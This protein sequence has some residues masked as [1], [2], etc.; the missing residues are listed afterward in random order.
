MIARN[1][2]PIS[3]NTDLMQNGSLSKLQLAKYQKKLK[4]AEQYQQ[5]GNIPKSLTL[6]DEIVS[7]NCSD[8]SIQIRIA[9]LL[10]MAGRG[11]AAI[12]Y[13][14][15]SEA[16]KQGNEDILMLL[17]SYYKALGMLT[18]AVTLYRQIITRNNINC[19]ALLEYATIHSI[20]GNHQHAIEYLERC[21]G[22]LD[23]EENNCKPD[24]S[25]YVDC[26]KALGLSYAST[27]EFDKGLVSYNKA[28][29]VKDDISIRT[30][31]ANLYEKSGDKDSA[32]E[33]LSGYSARQLTNVGSAL[34][35]SR[36]L[37]AHNNPG[38]CI[39]I[40][41]ATVKSTRDPQDL[42]ALF[43]QMGKVFE[44]TGDYTSAFR[45]YKNGN[46]SLPPSYNRTLEEQLFRKIK[47]AF[48]GTLPKSSNM[49]N[50]AIFITG[51]PR[52][53]TS[54]VEQ[55]LSAHKDITVGGEQTYFH[56]LHRTIGKALNMPYPDCISGLEQEHIDKLSESYQL[57]LDGKSG[58]NHFTDKLPHNFLNIGLINLVAPGSYIIHCKRNPID[59]CLS[60]YTNVFSGMHAYSHKL[61]DLAHYYMQYL[62][63]MEYWKTTQDIKWHDISYED[64]VAD[65]ENMVRS[66]IEFLELEWDQNCLTFYTLPRAIGTASYDQANKPVYNSSVMR[67]R[68][69]DKYIEPLL[70]LPGHYSETA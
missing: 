5:R 49:N 38:K 14:A 50:R 37:K 56:E 23:K 16:A 29:S 33:L 1:Y 65:T 3:P 55:I 24:K 8:T 25:I 57:Y 64:L 40:L 61:E 7:G 68:H 60:C 26:H 66:L 32:L 17:A 6:L 46:D 59:T 31:I 51:M 47:S 2:Q 4:K 52:S 11:K 45:A 21:A 63:L 19:A 12:D 58:S 10:F 15:Q 41:E 39:D 44:S 35:F 20:R 70:T 9:R 18:D 13:L 67:W 27:G 62:D 53:G 28:L 42:Y 34:V 69:F 30:G 43:V 22:I 48:S 36:L 54:L